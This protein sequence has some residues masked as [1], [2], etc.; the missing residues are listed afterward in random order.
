MV[1][2]VHHRLALFPGDLQRCD[3]GL[4]PPPGPGAA[5]GLAGADRPYVI[6]FLTDGQPTIGET[7]EDVAFNVE[8][9][10][11]PCEVVEGRPL[12][13]GFLVLQHGQTAAPWETATVHF[14]NTSTGKTMDVVA[15][16]DRADGHFTATATLPEPGYWSWHVTLQ[17]LASDHMPVTFAVYTADGKLP[18]YDPATTA[19]AIAQAKKDV[20]A[21]INEQFS[22]EIARLDN[23]LL[24]Q[25]ARSDRLLAQTGRIRASGADIDAI[26][27]A[28]RASPLRNSNSASLNSIPLPVRQT[29]INPFSS[30]FARSGTAM[31]C[32]SGSSSVPVMRIVRGSEP[33]S[34]TI[35]P[36]FLRA[37][38][39]RR[40]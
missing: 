30:S 22:G 1:D 23:L 6:I 2:A 8:N 20:T 5:P 25:Q 3:F 26:V 29:A 7:N 38:S 16:N 35:S 21:E 31:R 37:I 12:E 13:V 9:A 17:D 36:T 19:T 39:P 40:P 28:C 10:A 27:T 15:S 11:I 14:T 18:T 34:F 33:V 24:A 4:E 32:S